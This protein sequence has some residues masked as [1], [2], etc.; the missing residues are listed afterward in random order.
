MIKH[1]FKKRLFLSLTV[2]LGIL[3]FGTAILVI[4][5]LNDDLGHADVALVLGSKVETDGTPSARLRARLDQTLACYRAGYFPEVIVSGGIGKEGHDEAAVMR[6][7]LVGH[8]IPA[9]HILMDN[10][11][12]TTFASARNTRDIAQQVNFHTVFVISQYFHIPRARLALHRFGFATVYSVHAPYFE[13]RDVYSA[14][15]EFLGYLSY[16]VRRYP[17]EK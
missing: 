7:Y 6:D 17:S 16:L 12:I 5:G 4:A 3:F 2:V 9:E 10:N 14:P 15:R 8:G 13:E 1:S 11:G